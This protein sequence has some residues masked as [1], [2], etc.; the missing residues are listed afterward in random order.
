MINLKSNFGSK[1]GSCSEILWIV[2]LSRIEEVLFLKI[3]LYQNY[4]CA[5]KHINYLQFSFFVQFLIQRDRMINQT[6]NAGKTS[7]HRAT[8]GGHTPVIDVLLS[9]GADVN[10]LTTEDQT[11][12]HLAAE[13]CNKP[14]SKV[15]MTFSLTQVI[16][17]IA[18][19]KKWPSFLKFC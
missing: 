19:K 16:M 8:E 10:F 2:F 5:L 14:E 11:C 7:L 12:L 13:L 1:P 3:F 18:G 15:E 9:H 17:L 4:L 6:N